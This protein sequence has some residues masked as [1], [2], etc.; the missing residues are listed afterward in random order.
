MIVGMS[1]E[2]ILSEIRQA[3]QSL[4]LKPSTLCARATGNGHLPARL[5]TGG[6]ITIATM[7]K[8]RAFVRKEHARSK[9][10]GRSR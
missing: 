10:S 9:R 7:E 6:S 4:G 5:E 1:T 2:A 8:I 3:A